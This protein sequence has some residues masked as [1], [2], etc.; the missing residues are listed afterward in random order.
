[1]RLT[2]SMNHQGHVTI[3]FE[4]R[5]RGNPGLRVSN[6]IIFRWNH[7]RARIWPRVRIGTNWGSAG[8][9]RNIQMRTRSTDRTSWTVRANN[10]RAVAVAI[11]YNGNARTET[12]IL[13]QGPR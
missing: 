8:S 11:S 5:P 9:A 2:S 1:M 7:L 10:I 6:N 12:V 4:A 13:R 3:N